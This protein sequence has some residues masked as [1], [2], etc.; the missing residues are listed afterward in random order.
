MGQD[1]GFAD[2]PDAIFISDMPAVFISTMLG[3]FIPGMFMLES[4]PQTNG[5]NVSPNKI[6]F[7]KNLLNAHEGATSQ[8]QN[9]GFK[10]KIRFGGQEARARAGLA[11]IVL[12]QEGC[13]T[14][15]MYLEQTAPHRLLPLRTT[16]RTT[17]EAQSPGQAHGYTLLSSAPEPAYDD[18]R[19][20]V[21]QRKIQVY[22]PLRIVRN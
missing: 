7:T 15:E 2:V 4:C 1:A 13:Q 8:I 16:W 9:D 10:E 14:A 19:V 12:E 11:E 3:I 22:M 20:V 5:S 21:E 6:N 17:I 18:G